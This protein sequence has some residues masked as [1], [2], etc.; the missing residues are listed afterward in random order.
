MS[1]RDRPYSGDEGGP[2]LRLGF[3]KPS[4]A[5]TWL[6][7]ANVAVYVVELIAINWLDMRSFIPIFGLSLDGIRDFYFWQPLTYMF[8]HEPR[9]VLHLLMNMLGLYIFGSEFERTFGRQRFLQF[10]GICGVVGGMAYLLLSLFSSWHQ[11]IPLAGASGAVFGLLM[12]AVI[13]F[14]QIQVVMVIFPMPI[15][16]FALIWAG[17]LLLQLL[18][19]NVYNPGG[20]ICHIAGALTGVALFYS[21]GMMPGVRIGSH[22]LG[23]SRGEGAW[24]RRQRQAAEEQ[25]EVDRIL[26]KIH[27]EGISSLTRKERKTL[28]QATRHQRER[29]QELGRMDRL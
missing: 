25:A 18:G 28:T 20:E 14:P 23:R 5:V 9:G 21:W 29:E 10:Y 6:I 19:R 15:R 3:R 8:V 17:I 27:N 22:R 7:L 2:E 16:V 24:A 13:F 12:A 26:A 11:D 4:T 1:W